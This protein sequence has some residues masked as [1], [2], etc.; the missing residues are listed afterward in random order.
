MS[1]QPSNEEVDSEKWPPVILHGPPSWP[2]SLGFVGSDGR[3]GLR[4]LAQQQPA[5]GG[6]SCQ[7]PAGLS[8]TALLITSA[9]H[10][11]NSLSWRLTSLACC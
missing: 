3:A 7:T 6:E 11:S 1:V 5:R 4:V 9:K 2:P 10:T 8:T